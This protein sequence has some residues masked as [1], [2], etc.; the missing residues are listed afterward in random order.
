MSKENVVSFLSEA[1]KD[2][3]L[4]QQMQA[5]TNQDEMVK[6]A[7]E[8]GYTFSA[9][10]VDEVLTDLK[11]DPS[12]FGSLAEAILELFSPTHDNYP[13]IGVQPFS[14]DSHSSH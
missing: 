4:K 3:Q 6:V 1:T 11:K 14:G 8:A 5:T 12:F 10:H 9:E 7:Q 13:V 2:E